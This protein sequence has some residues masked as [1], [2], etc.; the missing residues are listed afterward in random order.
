MFRK[1]PSTQ[2]KN[3]SG[4]SILAVSRIKKLACK[5][6]ERERQNKLR[7]GGEQKSKLGYVKIKKKKVKN[8]LGSLEILRTIRKENTVDSNHILDEQ[9]NVKAF[10]KSSCLFLFLFFNPDAR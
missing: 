2:Q 6:R 10:K 1:D 3:K 5:R 4:C 7:S 9:K 8:K